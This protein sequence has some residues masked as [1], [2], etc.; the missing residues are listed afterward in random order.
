VAECGKGGGGVTSRLE[1]PVLGLTLTPG[2]V[3]EEP[4]GL[5]ATV[6]QRLLTILLLHHSY[7]FM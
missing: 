1:V 5:R 2:L 3:G 4:N 6:T 7:S